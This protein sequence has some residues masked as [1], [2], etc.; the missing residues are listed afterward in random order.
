MK[1]KEE[2]IKGHP[3]FSYFNSQTNL[4]GDIGVGMEWKLLQK[5]QVPAFDIQPGILEGGN[6]SFGCSLSGILENSHTEVCWRSHDCLLVAQ[7]G[8]QD[9]LTE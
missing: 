7:S 9:G 2:E 4:F 5:Q 3:L 6:V 1:I 8:P